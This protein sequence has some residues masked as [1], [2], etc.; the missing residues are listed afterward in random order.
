M[1]TGRIVIYSN[2]RTAN[3]FTLDKYC[4]KDEPR[5]L[6]LNL[7]EEESFEARSCHE[8]LEELFTLSGQNC[9]SKL[10]EIN[11]HHMNVQPCSNSPLKRF[12]GIGGI[13]TNQVRN[14]TKLSLPI[15]GYLE[16]VKGKPSMELEVKSSFGANSFRT[17]LSEMMSL[18]HVE[19]KF[20]EN[21]KYNEL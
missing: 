13:D 19:V 14:L 5:S 17:I 11:V 6:M 12:K 7:N 10:K 16:Y 20:C 2:S 18:V 4:S 3:I 8:V 1:D 21:S 15:C 9:L